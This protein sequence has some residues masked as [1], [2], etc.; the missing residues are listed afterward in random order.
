M[1][2]TLHTPERSVTRYHPL[3]VALH[4]LLAVLIIA[5]LAVGYFVLAPMPSTDADKIGVLKLHMAGGMVI[6]VLMLVRFV[7]RLCTA[8]PQSLNTAKPALDRLAAVVHYAF[9][10]LVLAMVVTGLVTAVVS[11]IN[12]IVFGDTGAPL[13]ASLTG[14]PSRVAHG[15]LAALLAALI[16]L[17]VLAAL[18]HRFV[19]KNKRLA[20][21][22]FGRRQTS[23]PSST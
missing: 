4:W 23:T 17:H 14:Y 7:V 2:Q 9:Y 19:A 3:L 12:L 20:R 11:G 15:Y 22:G 5:A 6:L 8:K 18:Y 1:T 13:P 16:A 21:M 10:L